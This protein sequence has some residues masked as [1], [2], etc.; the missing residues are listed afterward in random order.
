MECTVEKREHAAKFSKIMNGIKLELDEDESLNRLSV[1]ER[2]NR[3]R[4]G[5]RD[6]GITTLYFNF[7]RYLMMSSSINGDLPANLQ[8]KW[9]DSINPPWECDYHFDI[10]LQMN[11]WMSEPCNMPDCAEALLKYTESFY[12]S[13]QEAAEM[14]YGCRGIYLPLQTDAWGISTSESFGWSAWIGAAPW[15]AQHFW[16]HYLYSG[17]IEFLRSRGY[18]FFKAVA[19]FYE[20]YLVEDENGVM[21]IMPS[22]SPENSFVEACGGSNMPVGICIS[23][24]MDVQLAYDALGYAAQTANILE[25][26]EEKAKHW[27]RLQSMLPD[28][29]IGA[30]GRLLEWGG[31]FEE[32]EPGHRHLSHLYGVYPSD[33]FTAE[34][35][36]EKYEAARKSLEFRLEHGG[37]HTGWSRAWVACLQARFGNAEAFY[38]HFVALI[39]DFATE[40]MLDLHPPRIFQI[41]GNLGAVAALLEAVV[42]FTDGKVHLLRS[43]PEEWSCGRLE[44][45]KVPGGLIINVTWKDRRIEKLDITIGFGKKV[46]VSNVNGEEMAFSGEEGQKICYPIL[47]EEGDANGILV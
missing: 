13:G 14:L 32:K 2:L 9:N 10:N 41:D 20:D 39:R 30:D 42:S 33:L 44:G 29:K 8:G 15:I 6:N 17:D 35:R 7:G 31:E 27:K 46:I 25:V 24:A 43:L 18:K 12:A 21:Q 11:Y 26:D 37:G 45:I 1:G 23:S 16:Q 47:N 3:I 40:T 19:E 22:Q 5:R 38:E 34:T 4:E 36:P 28:F